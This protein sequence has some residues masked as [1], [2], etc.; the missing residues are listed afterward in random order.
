MSKKRRNLLA[1][2]AVTL[3]LGGLLWWLMASSDTAGEPEDHTHITS[4]SDHDHTHESD[5]GTL[6]NES[7]DDLR[8][9]VFRNANGRYTAYVDSKKGE[10]VFRE[11]EGLPVNNAFMEYVW[12]GAVQL[13]YSHII[14]TT[15]ADD[16]SAKA[17]GLDKPSLTVTASFKDGHT[18]SFQAG[19]AV[20]GEETDVYYTLLKGDKHVYACPIDIPFF[21]GDSYFINDDIFY[22]YDEGIESSDIKIGNITLSGDAF[23]GKFVMKVNQQSDMSDPAYGY[24]YMVTKPIQWPVKNT[25]ASELVYDLTYLMADDVVQRNPSRKDLVSYGLDDPSL[26]VTFRRNGK[27]CTLYVSKHDKEMMY[28][29]LKG[30][31]MVY[32]LKPSSLSILHELSPQNLYSL[33][34]VPLQLEPISGIDVSWEETTVKLRVTREQN[35]NAMGESD[36]IYTYAAK[37][38]GKSIKYSVYTNFVKQLQGS[39]IQQWDVA[40]PEGKPAVTLKIAYFDNYGRKADT[41]SFYPYQEREYAVVWGDKPV[42][43]V[44]ATWLHRLLDSAGQL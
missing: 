6:V 1:L 21:M 9:V 12:Y 37:A 3:L 26:T 27:K 11:L 20:K 16:Y 43:T 31:K 42:N 35:E 15:D 7:A 39:V 41:I 14:T 38:N 28:A 24:S 10:V 25:A 17:Y 44:S 34:A 4:E 8:K 18:V 33:N 30:G 19:D 36:V 22:E 40:M 2:L 23:D 5:T 29:M 32:L 13:T